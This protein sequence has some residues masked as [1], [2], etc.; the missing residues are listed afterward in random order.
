MYKFIIS[1]KDLK[2]SYTSIRRIEPN[3]FEPATPLYDIQQL[4]DLQILKGV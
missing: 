3:G 4:N 2:N 1:Q